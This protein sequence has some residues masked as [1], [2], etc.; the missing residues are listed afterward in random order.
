MALRYDPNLP[1][2]PPFTAED[3]RPSIYRRKYVQARILQI[4]SI[5]C[6]QL[7]DQ[8]ITVLLSGGLDSRFTLAMLR[9]VNPEVKIEALCMAFNDD[10]GEQNKAAEVARRYDANFRLIVQDNPLQDLQK[11]IPLIDR[12]QWN[13]YPHYLF[14]QARTKTVY[15]GDGGDELWLGYIWRYQTGPRNA[16]EYLATHANDYLGDQEMQRMMPGFDPDRIKSLIGYPWHGEHQLEPI[17]MVMLADLNGKLLCDYLHQVRTY[18]AR[19]CLDI[20]SLFLA[21]SMIQYA[22]AVDSSLKYDGTYGKLVIREALGNAMLEGK[23]G[24]G[25]DLKSLYHR[26]GREFCKYWL[27]TPECVKR[28]IINDYWLAKRLADPDPGVPIINKLLH[29]AAL[30]IFLLGEQDTSSVIAQTQTR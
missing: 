27:D 12:P 30:E 28:G 8:S 20:R 23:Q 19:F 18:S 3:I 9:A 2:I 13:L 25:P 17:E 10:K 21:P 11:I 14:E 4:A 16:S 15:T 1:A 24:F 6:A 5:A 22:L 26:H 7:A 29:I